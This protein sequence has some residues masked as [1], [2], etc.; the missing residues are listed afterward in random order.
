MLTMLLYAGTYRSLSVQFCTASTSPNIPDNYAETLP[1]ISG[2]YQTFPN[3]YSKN[4]D[5]F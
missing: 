4:A 5:N 3:N 1:L 2:G